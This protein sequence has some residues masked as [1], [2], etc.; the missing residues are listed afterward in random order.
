MAS[1]ESPSSLWLSVVMHDVYPRTNTTTSAVMHDVY[2][3]TDTTISVVMHD[4]YQRTNTT[5]S[6]V[7][8]DVYQRTNTTTLIATQKL[9][10]LIFV[11]GNMPR[12]ELYQL[13]TILC[14]CSGLTNLAF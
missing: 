6:V 2:Q 8:H 11:Q 7:M 10:C 12:H 14:G 5:T 13:G 9:D 3:R 1:G 4:I